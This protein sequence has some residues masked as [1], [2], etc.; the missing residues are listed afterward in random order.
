MR[1]NFRQGIVSHQTGGFLS[2][3]GSGHVDLLAN[4]KPTRVAIAHTYTNYLHTENN[5]V[6]NAWLG[7]FSAG[8]DYWLYWQFNPLTFERTFGITTL[9]PVAQAAEPGSGNAQ[10]VAAIP[11][12]PGIGS[13]TVNQHYVLSAGKPFVVIGS[14]AND[15][16]YT[17][18]S[19]S[20]NTTSGQ[21]TIVVAE[22]VV[23]SVGDGEAT[24][25][26]D[27]LGNPLKQTGRIWFNTLTNRHYIRQSFGWQEIIAVFAAIL[28][29]SNTF[30]STSINGGT[31]FTGTQIGNTDSALA[32]RVLFDSNSN[33]I[34]RDDG[35]FFTTEDQFYSSAARVDGIRLESNVSRAQF[36]GGSAVSKFTVMAYIDDGRVRVAQYNDSSQTVVG[37]LTEDLL[38]SE[39]G[40]IVLQG[41]ITNLDWNWSTIGVPLWIDNGNLVN[42]DPH[43]SDPITYATSKVPVARV[44]S[45]DTI[46]FEQGLGAVGPAGP[47]GSIENLPYATTTSLGAVTLVTQSSDANLAYVISDTDYRLTNARSPLPHTHPSSQ[48]SFV[49]GAGVDS[50]SVQDALVELGTEKLNI[51]G[52]TMTGVLTLSADPTSALHAAT[53]Q[54]VDNSLDSISSLY[55]ADTNSDTFVAVGYDQLSGLGTDTDNNNVYIQTGLSGS[56][57]SGSISISTGDNAYNGDTGSILIATGYHDNEQSGSRSGNITIETGNAYTEDA[58]SIFLYGGGSGGGSGGDIEIQAGGANGEGV[59]SRGGFLSFTAGGSTTGSGGDV[60]I[61]AGESVGN[62]GGDV[63][64][65]SGYS[66]YGLTSGEI[67]ILA[68][69]SYEGNGGGVRI[70]SGYSYYGKG[71]NVHIE[72]GY[73]YTTPGSVEIR[74]REHGGSSGNIMLRAD[75]GQQLDLDGG[76]NIDILPGAGLSATNQGHVRLFR[77]STYSTSNIPEIRFQTGLRSLPDLEK[78][79]AIK[80][81]TSVVGGELPNYT[82]TLPSYIGA[83]EDGLMLV[84]SSSGEL[85]FQQAPYDIN[86]QGFGTLNDGDILGRYVVPRDIVI[87]PIGHVGFALTAPS[88]SAATF[89]IYKG[90]ST[91]SP[92]FSPISIGTLTFNATS[93]VLSSILFDS[94]VTF[95]TGD[96]ITI[97]CTTASSIADITLTLRGKLALMG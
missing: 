17:V 33:P 83:L 47:P 58:G 56:I 86:A 18:V 91:G 9:E 77:Q 21:T 48:I 6:A 3:N 31:N 79:V 26:I 89:T 80:G 59:D 16:T 93:Q 35:T 46:I 49:P 81:P 62:F 43:V 45:S 74:T 1:I 87:T 55:I 36:T 30:I 75:G 52:D 67:D 78:Y 19:S 10:I 23:S 69:Y 38:D 41:V 73:G 37:M 34:K 12:D 15:G 61:R 11:G 66:E 54:Y 85:E 65:E 72:A 88:V 20:Y 8:T 7:P 63:R 64:I 44:L 92:P 60:N 51:A 94:D 14:T 96:I 22:S 76:G 53:K 50:L 32:G 84:S 2:I 97:E 39:E 13:F 57:S 4:T 42:I 90:T 24:L 82:I 40:A 28:T 71:G 29:N 5:T 27:Y 95:I 70:E 25:D 68:A